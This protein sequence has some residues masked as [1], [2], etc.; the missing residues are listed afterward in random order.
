M[1]EDGYPWSEF[2][3]CYNRFEPDRE[4]TKPSEWYILVYYL[5]R[6]FIMY[7]D[8]EDEGEEDDSVRYRRSSFVT[9]SIDTTET[10]RA[11][12]W[13]AWL[14]RL[15]KRNEGSSIRGEEDSSIRR[16]AVRSR[17]RSLVATSISTA[18]TSR[19]KARK[20]WLGRLFKKSK[21][22]PV[23][24][25]ETSQGMAWR[26]WVRALFTKSEKNGEKNGPNPV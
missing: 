11:E 21:Q 18:E 20:A 19:A 24:T 10:S 9:P 17:R 25:A 13:K 7:E 16:D 23:E 5:L 15:F 14:G 1:M 22:S 8:S 3:E 4:D 2:A 12:S 6:P 26:G